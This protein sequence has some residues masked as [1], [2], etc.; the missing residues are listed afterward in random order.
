MK[1]IN[2]RSFISAPLIL[3]FGNITG[4]SLISKTQAAP[5][6]PLLIEYKHG[7]ASGDPLQTKVILWTRLTLNR[8]GLNQKPDHVE[9]HALN[10]L[11]QVARN[12]NFTDI[13]SQG[14]VTT[15]AQHD[16][17]V[18]VDAS[19]L[20]P[21]NR[22]F[23]RFICNGSTSPIGRT[24]TLASDTNG[25]LS[26]EYKEQAELAVVSCS[27][28]GYGYFN[29]YQEISKQAN[30]TAV[31]HLGDYIYEYANH[32]YSDPELSNK[33][34]S[35]LPLTEITK[36]DEY[37]QR[38]NTYRRDPQLQ[39]AHAAHPFIC[40]WDD[41]EFANDSWRDG[42]QNHQADEGDW[43][44]RREFAIKAYRE[45]L[46]IR[47]PI[48]Q[49]DEATAYRR[50][51]IGS[52]ASLIMLDTRIAGRSK[53]VDYLTE[54]IWQQLPFDVRPMK[55][56]NNPIV[57]TDPAVLKTLKAADTKMVTIPFD[58]SQNPPQ[59]IVD[60]TALSALDLSQLPENLALIPDA[61]R[62]QKELLNN[63]NRQLLGELQE[64]WLDDA[65]Q[66]SKKRKIPWQILG[67]QILMGN[68]CMPDMSELLDYKKG[69]SAS[70]IEAIIGLGKLNL[71][72]NTDAW[73]G[74]NA[75]RQRTLNSIKNNAN[76][77]INLAGDTHNS[78][79]FNLVPDN[80][81]KPVAV[82]MATPSISSPG[83]ENYLS[84][85]QP[86][87][88]SAQLVDHNPHL[89]YQ[90]SHQRGWLKLTITAEH[91]TGQWNY[92]S[93]VKTKHYTPISGPAYRVAVD[94][95]QLEPAESVSSTRQ[96]RTLNNA[97]IEA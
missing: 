3:G 82:E 95:H 79:A 74:Y 26:E 23:Y 51:E 43:H 78:W 71:P 38:Y 4:F 92:V 1:N 52:L 48:E 53:P 35:V 9:R 42:A 12:S 30:L 73:D 50:F 21:N 62:I 6:T 16:Y 93:T 34:R 18:K 70:T 84:N 14:S 28:Y 39:A 44:Q 46:P 69:L 75:A 55:T 7:V 60:W 19:N 11:W 37:R 20:A 97:L 15:S 5:S 65:L 81:E 45:W 59:A 8:Q 13:V 57:I 77:V 80:A 91:A 17:T 96:T 68:V 87:T 41:H 83:L 24:R 67:Q 29:V 49:N 85:S 72:Y 25:S 58:I 56:G 63:P 36:L 86:E 31:L 47:D 66:D 32:V 90:N 33:N 76:N 2:R 88:L 94:E 27:N 64:Q 61:K 89:I 54:I 40:I 22:Y 10:V